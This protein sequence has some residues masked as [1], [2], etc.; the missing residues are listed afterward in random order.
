MIE[1]DSFSCSGTSIINLDQVVRIIKYNHN[2]T[3]Y[4]NLL[5]AVSDFVQNEPQIYSVLIDEEDAQKVFH[6]IGLTL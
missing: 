1:E 3:L 4:Y 6:A 2:K 5:F